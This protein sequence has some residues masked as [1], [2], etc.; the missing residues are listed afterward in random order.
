MIPSPHEA[1][2][3]WWANTGQSEAEREKAMQ[4]GRRVDAD[5]DPLT[6]FFHDVPQEV[7][8]EAWAQGPPV[9]SD[10]PFGQPWPLEAWP[11]V[12]TRMVTGLDDRLF[13]AGF[14]RR[15]ARERLGITPDE[16]PG[17]HLVALSRPAELADRLH[18]FAA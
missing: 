18:A 17:G 11:D 13:P 4:D 2:G 3:D 9:Q 12:P 15:I 14:Q 1:A 5:F 7:T 6:M 16:M 10:T 8:D